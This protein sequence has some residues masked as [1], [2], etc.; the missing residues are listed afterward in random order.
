[1][2]PRDHKTVAVQAGYFPTHPRRQTSSFRRDASATAGS[3]P[4][5]RYTGRSIR[6]RHRP[7]TVGDGR[8]RSPGAVLH[9]GLTRA[10]FAG[11]SFPDNASG[12]T[13]DR[14]DDEPMDVS[15]LG[16]TSRLMRCDAL[17]AHR[18]S[19]QQEQPI[20]HTTGEPDPRPGTSTFQRT[21][22]VSLHSVGG[23]AVLDAPVAC[24][25]RHWG[26]KRSASAPGCAATDATSA[27]TTTT[28]STTRC[29]RIVPR[30][31]SG[32]NGPFGHYFTDVQ[33]SRAL[34]TGPESSEP[35][36]EDGDP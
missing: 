12:R 14:Q 33:G 3:L 26:Q 27:A 10:L 1:M 5:R 34:R 35:G 29:R 7:L 13:V 4:C 19:G 2:V 18:D 11:G 24:G 20:A 25:P 16:M 36:V 31:P 9:R 22:R 15:R 30:L 28:T 6:R 21:F 23:F 8:T 32:P 17:N